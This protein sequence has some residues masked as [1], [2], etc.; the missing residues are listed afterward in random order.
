MQGF[1]E[2]YD[3]FVALDTQI[4]GVS[5]DPW[6]A[7]NAFAGSLG[8]DFPLLGDW[9][10]NRVSKAYDVYN[11]DRYVAGRVTYVIDGSGVIR[12]VIDEPR[13]MERHSRDALAAVRA[14]TG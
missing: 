7:A 5:V 2:A 9:P 10:L 14:L 3:Q 1:V 12:A 11:E 6:P 4:I 13:D 8:A